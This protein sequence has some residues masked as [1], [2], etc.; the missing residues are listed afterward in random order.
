MIAK[1]LF[2][3]L[4]ELGQRLIVVEATVVS[5]TEEQFEI[6]PVID[7]RF[8]RVVRK[9]AMGGLHHTPLAAVLWAKERLIA[10]KKSLAAR[11]DLEDAKKERE[12][13]FADVRL[14]EISELLKELL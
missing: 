1:R 2:G 13:R 8:R 6:V 11:Q 12:I 4:E 9:D 3:I 10:L 5:E 7:F 14:Q